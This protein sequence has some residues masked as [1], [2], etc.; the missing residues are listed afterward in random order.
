MLTVNPTRNNRATTNRGEEA[1]PPPLGQARARPQPLG[2]AVQT[3]ARVRV[4]VFLQGK[5]EVQV[6]TVQPALEV[7][8]RW[9]DRLRAS[10]VLTYEPA[11]ISLP[12]TCHPQPERPLRE[13][14]IDVGGVG[15]EPPAIYQRWD[16]RKVEAAVGPQ[17]LAAEGA[18]P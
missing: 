10:P 5:R 17:C 4:I 15:G 6:R 3:A 1:K 8:T 18:D 12:V 7:G 16:S 13:D 11:Q 2:T 14:Q 9:K